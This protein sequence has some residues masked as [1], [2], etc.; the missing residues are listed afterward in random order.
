MRVRDRMVSSWW[1]RLLVKA[2][3]D[4]VVKVAWKDCSDAD[5]GRVMVTKALIT[6][7]V[8]YFD[9]RFRAIVR[10]CLTHG[11]PIKCWGK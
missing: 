9:R 1:R 8:L 10:V 5:V 3:A 2:D 11:F 7:V 4:D 6:I